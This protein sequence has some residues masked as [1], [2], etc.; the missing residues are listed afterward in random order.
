[1]SKNKLKQYIISIY[2]EK[3]EKTL[4]TCSKADTYQVFKT[5]PKLE[6]YFERIKN[7]KQLKSFTKLKL[8]DHKFMIEERRRKRPMLPRNERLYDTCGKLKDE[9]HFLIECDKWKYDRYENF[10]TITEEIPHFEQMSDSRT[11]FIFL[12]TQENETIFNL[13]A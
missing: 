7:I 1:M 5:I 6:K 10:K 3:C 9:I 13:I 4:F 2:Y 11:N 12:M 8:S